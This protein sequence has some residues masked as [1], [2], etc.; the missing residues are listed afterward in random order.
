MAVCH[1]VTDD[2][3]SLYLSVPY[4]RGWQIYINGKKT[5]YNLIDNCLYSLPLKKGDNTIEMRYVCPMLRVG[6]VISILG[7]LLTITMT[8]IE[9][10]KRRLEK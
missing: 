3:H 1:N 4:D 10:K 7:I 8:L 6:A 2:H 9:N 5:S